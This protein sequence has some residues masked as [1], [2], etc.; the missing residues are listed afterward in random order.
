[1]KIGL[2]KWLGI[3]VL[4]YLYGSLVVRGRFARLFK[5]WGICDKCHVPV[6]VGGHQIF[7]A[8]FAIGPG[9]G[10]MTYCPECGEFVVVRRG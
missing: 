8:P 6:M 1:M 7:P 9:R 3:G 10:M 2:K 5:Y 4:A